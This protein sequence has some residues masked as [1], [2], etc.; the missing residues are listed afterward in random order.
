M[1]TNFSIF[2]ILK[3][4]GLTEKKI[5]NSI[6]EKY[7]LIKSDIFREKNLEKMRSLI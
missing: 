2:S 4:F 5:F 3:I 1:K 6:K 7:F